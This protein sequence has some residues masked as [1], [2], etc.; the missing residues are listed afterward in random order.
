MSKDLALFFV[1]SAAATLN[2]TLLAAVLVMLL[3][4]HPKR[5]MLGYLAGACTISVAVGLV[6]A[7]ALH[8]SRIATTPGRIVTPGGRRAPAP[9]G[10]RTNRPAPEAHRHTYGRPQHGA[11]RN[12]I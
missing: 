3:L 2:P 12:E 5:L 1:D 10:A 4:P 9:A 8:G 6:A 7:F 11:G